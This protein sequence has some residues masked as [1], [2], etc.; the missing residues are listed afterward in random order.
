[1]L[2]QSF[3]TNNIGECGSGCGQYGGECF[4][5]EMLKFWKNDS[6]KTLA[7]N[8]L[9]EKLKIASFHGWLNIS[10]YAIKVIKC[11]E[12]HQCND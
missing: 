9:G 11:I 10:A 5:K 6:T 1:M 3:L 7:R 8:V 12:L 2:E 4:W